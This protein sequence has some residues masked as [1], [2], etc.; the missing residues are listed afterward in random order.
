LQKDCLNAFSGG[1]REAQILLN[2]LEP[3]QRF[4]FLDDPP[5]IL[6]TL[7][8]GEIECRV[9]DSNGSKTVKVNAKL[10]ITITSSHILNFDDDEMT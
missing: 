2:T 9:L 1:N 5:S 4:L 8:D 10:M 7:C 6:K 3:H